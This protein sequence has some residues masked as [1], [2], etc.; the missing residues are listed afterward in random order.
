MDTLF[1]PDHPSFQHDNTRKIARRH[2]S[3]S[4]SGILVYAKYIVENIFSS[5]FVGCCSIFIENLSCIGIY[6]RNWALTSKP[7]GFRVGKR[8]GLILRSKMQVVV[9]KTM[10]FVILDTRTLSFIPMIKY[11]TRT[12]IFVHPAKESFGFKKVL[13]HNGTM[14]TWIINKKEASYAGL[15]MRKINCCMVGLVHMDEVCRRKLFSRKW[16]ARKTGRSEK[17]SKR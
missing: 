15:H 4:S 2:L 16:R 12:I 8:I 6:H 11:L 14:C 17:R 5:R 9:S 13:R 7:L 3:S 1:C 10:I